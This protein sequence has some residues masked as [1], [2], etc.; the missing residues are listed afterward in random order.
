MAEPGGA[1][2]EQGVAEIP[3][4]LHVNSTPF[5]FEGGITLQQVMGLGECTL[6]GGTHLR[7]PEPVPRHQKNCDIQNILGQSVGNSNAA[8]HN[9]PDNFRN[10]VTKYES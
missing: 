5:P 7:Q 9:V 2:K 10:T 3:S 4:K 8:R 1:N 6:V